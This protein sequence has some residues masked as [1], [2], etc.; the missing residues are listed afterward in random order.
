MTYRD[1]QSKLRVIDGG[2]SRRIE[3]APDYYQLR[4]RM[5]AKLALGLL[6]A[7]ALLAALLIASCGRIE[8]E[9]WIPRDGSPVLLELGEG[10]PAEVAVEAARIWEPTGVR[11]V[12][13]SSAPAR[14]VRVEMSSAPLHDDAGGS[15][16][17]WPEF[18]VRLRYADPALL[19]HELGHA[20]G[21]HHLSTC[22]LMSPSVCS[23]SLTDADL[24]E[25]A[26]TGF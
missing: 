8:V 25:F 9:S 16:Q 20:L 13:S 5:F 18:R 19:A 23:A 2:R 12:L 15:F 4:R 22:A 6:G 17:A 7:A 21:L 10:V 1:Y 24:A 11:F 14:T 26:R 3:I